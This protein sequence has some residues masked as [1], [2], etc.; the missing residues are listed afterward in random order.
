ME[1]KIPIVSFRC[2]TNRGD[3]NVY[4]FDEYLEWYERSKGNGFRI[5][6]KAIADV[7]VVR[8]GKAEVTLITKEKKQITLL[9]YKVDEMLS[10]LYERLNAI[11][12]SGNDAPLEEDMLSK[13][14][15]LAKLHESGAL[16]D[17]EF[18]QAKAKL[19]S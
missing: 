9:L 15:R 5:W 11:N 16:T 7:R 10:V 13:L 19:L 14:E 12:G 3:G 1:N 8:T 6:Y 18:A 4:L 17:E 2:D